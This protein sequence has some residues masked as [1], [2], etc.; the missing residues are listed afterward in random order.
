MNEL[1]I[2]ML[3]S[4]L[5][6]FLLSLLIAYKLGRKR[7]IGFGWSFLLSAF[8]NP[9]VGFII[10]MLSKKTTEPP[11]QQSNFKEALGWLIMLF[12][13]IV[14]IILFL[15]SVR[16]VQLPYAIIISIFGSLGL[17]G[18]G[19][20]LILLGKGE[21]PQS[22]GAGEKKFNL[23]EYA[24]AK[25]NFGN[26]EQAIDDLNNLINSY[27][28]FDKAYLY[29]ALSKDAIG[30]YEEA[31]RDFNTALSINPEVK[32]NSKSP[33]LSPSAWS[34]F[35]NAKNEYQKVFEENSSKQKAYF[36]RALQKSGLGE[37]KEAVE[38]LNKVIEL[39]P[40]NSEAYLQRGWERLLINDIKGA[41][42]DWEKAGEKGIDE[43]YKLL[44][45]YGS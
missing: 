21:M 6:V 43:G 17:I 40:E 3:I 19:Y 1:A 28:L 14:L 13:I 22:V 26:I 5:V 33:N 16:N 32:E 12:G 35:Q 18:L 7:Q 45:K 29:R 10:V 30:D 2:I 4:G 44:E 31:V 34:Y 15:G 27:P 23:L 39:N 8:L 41:C 24:K 42:E 25:Y 20:Y 9:L 37:R 11:P 36:V 38:D